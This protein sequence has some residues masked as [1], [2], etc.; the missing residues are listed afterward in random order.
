[1]RTTNRLINRI[2]GGV[3][4]ASLGVIMAAGSALS[5]A[6]NA[7]T[8]FEFS[9]PAPI[10]NSKLKI[11]NSISRPQRVAMYFRDRNEPSVWEALGYDLP[12]TAHDS[13]LP[14]FLGYVP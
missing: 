9:I 12:E 11:Q 6:A 2:L 13:D 5:G 1:M 7:R 3:L 8:N 14:G 4:L 10:Q